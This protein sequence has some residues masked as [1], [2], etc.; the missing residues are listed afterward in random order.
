[1]RHAGQL[2]PPL[3]GWYVP[4][5]VQFVHVVSPVLA[6]NVPTSHCWHAV[7]ET[8]PV[9]VENFPATHGVQEPAADRAYFPA[10]HVVQAV[11]GEI[12]FAYLPATH[13]SQLMVPVDAEYV[14]AKQLMHGVPK[15]V[16]H[17]P[18]GHG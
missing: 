15:Y 9:A 5:T 8:A 4:L 13:T 12:P 3:F 7:S 11:T 1:M 14:P 16:L 2:V 18:T 6:E 17:I 10:V